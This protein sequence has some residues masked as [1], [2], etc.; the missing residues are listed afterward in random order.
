M[1]PRAGVTIRD[2]ARR[3]GVS[4]TAVSHALNDKGTISEHTRE[5]VRQAAAELD[6]QADAFAR[7]MRQGRI[8]VI[9]LVMR[10]LD[11]L[12]DYTPDGVDVFVRFAGILSAKALARGW[13]L[14]LLPDLTRRPVPSMAFAMDGYVVMSPLEGD[15]VTELLDARGIAYVTYGREPAR[16][17][18]DSWAA[19]DDRDAAHQLL[20]H[21]EAAGAEEVALVRGTDRNAWNLDYTDVYLR[22]CAERSRAPRLYEQ[23]EGSGVAGGAEVAE[24][25]LEDGLPDAVLCLTGR[26]AA[27][28]Q[29]HLQDRGFLV[30]R[31]VMVATGSDSEP[32]RAS[33]P[34]IT[35]IQMSP[36]DTADAL[37]D[38]LRAKL[39]GGGAPGPRLTRSRLRPRAST[40]S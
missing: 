10:S 15:P 18:F 27:G 19:E 40:R 14:T 26:H 22:W 23:P 25:I 29:R 21:L 34:A 36:A 28:L 35:A 17:G 31:D 37:L 8:G 38:L 32:S 7:G 24:R 39:D 16:A 30:P 3:A 1:G 5:R 4:I 20:R 11:A 12:G 9:G 2:V 13:S 33:R 6:Y